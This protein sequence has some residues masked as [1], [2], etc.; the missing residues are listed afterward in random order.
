M[1]A[2]GFFGA[3]AAFDAVFSVFVV[4]CVVLIVVTMRW[5]VR[6]DR[7]S[8][9]AWLARRSDGDVSKPMAPPS[10]AGRRLPA[11]GRQGTDRP[12]SGTS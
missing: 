8:R 7:S 2:K 3:D 11:R 12:P 4:A 1:G 10:V 9:A 5:A 6:R